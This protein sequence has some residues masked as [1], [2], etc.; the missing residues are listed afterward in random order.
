MCVDLEEKKILKL[1]YIR[2]RKYE[3]LNPYLKIKK[4]NI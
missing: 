4:R 1:H 3:A 2:R